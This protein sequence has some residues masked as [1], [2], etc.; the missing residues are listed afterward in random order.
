MQSFDELKEVVR[1]IRNKCPWDKK[2]S[3]ESLK[4]YFIEEVYE[5]LEAIDNKDFNELKEE[6]GD[7]LLQIMLHSEIA[8]E[9][10]HF[11][12]NDVINTVKDKM[13]ERHPHVFGELKDRT[14]DSDDVLTNWEIIK[15]K[16][17]KRE[18]VLDGLPKA[19]PAL[20]R[21]QRM[22]SKSSKVGFDWE[23]VDGAFDKVKE[24]LAE[25]E[26][27]LGSDNRKRQEEEFGDLLF[28]LVNVGRHLGFD[29]EETLQRTSNKYEK[30]FRY[31]EKQYKNHEEMKKASLEELD[32]HWDTV[33]KTEKNDN[34]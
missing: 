32:N 14:L 4:K 20:I 8:S 13:I 2:Q 33:K 16:S 21:A 1:E 22:Q 6:L 27:E 12:I 28:A 26:N 10:N 25:F 7:V 29:T 31:V 18:S 23:H 9:E 34:L 19:M 17:K 11:D 24:E 30:R 3:H 15:A 5:A